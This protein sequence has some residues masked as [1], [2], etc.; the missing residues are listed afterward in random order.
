VMPT[1]ST[2]ESECEVISNCT[3]FVRSLVMRSLLISYASERMLVC[4]NLVSD[5]SV[6]CTEAA[7]R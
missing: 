2:L 1:I 3:G 5:M 6:N 4:A 7:I